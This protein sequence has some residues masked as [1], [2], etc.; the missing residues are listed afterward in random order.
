MNCGVRYLSQSSIVLERTRLQVQSGRAASLLAIPRILEVAVVP[1]NLLL[2]GCEATAISYSPD[3]Y[4][5]AFRDSTRC[6]AH[7][8]VER[9]CE[10]RHLPRERAS[11]LG[12]F[13]LRDPMLPANPWS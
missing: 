4:S 10:Q 2:N 1:C 11:R 6:F 3:H 5:V 13:A 8:S 7:D 12:E 9:N